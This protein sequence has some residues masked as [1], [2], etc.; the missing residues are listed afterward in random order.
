MTTDKV[1]W[2]NYYKENKEKIS[3]RRKKKYAEDAKFREAVQKRN[4]EW[5]Q[6]H[7]AERFQKL[8]EQ[9]STIDPYA[10]SYRWKPVKIG[11]KVQIL[12]SANVVERAA[13]VTRT[14]IMSWIEKGILPPPTFVDENGNR[15]F[16]KGYVEMVQAIAPYKVFGFAAMKEAVQRELAR[17][18]GEQCV[19][20]QSHGQKHD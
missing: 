7:R 18:G 12:V 13:N 4:R 3:Q 1:Y 8:K 9:I 11:D 17:R 10:I 19:V 5:W 2:Q 20:E 14:A 15:W 16:S 6:R